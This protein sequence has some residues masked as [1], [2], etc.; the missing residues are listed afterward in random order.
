MSRLGLA[1]Q[2]VGGHEW[3]PGLTREIILGGNIEFVNAHGKPRGPEMLAS[4]DFAFHTM[5]FGVSR[6]RSDCREQRTASD[7]RAYNGR[8][9]ALMERNVCDLLNLYNPHDPLDHAWTIPSPWYFDKQ[10]EKLEQ[11]SVFAKTWQVVG[12]ADQVKNKGD[13]FTAELE[14]E[15]IVVARGEDGVLRA[16]FNVCR[17]H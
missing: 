2:A 7:G 3:V 10:I 5:D 17:H 16:F 13:F 11:Q 9:G 6:R 1:T 8:A 15:P 14:T 12:R 4:S